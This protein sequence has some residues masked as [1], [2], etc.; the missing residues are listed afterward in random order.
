MI[1]CPNCDFEI[2][3]KGVHNGI[4]RPKCPRCHQPFQLAIFAGQEPKVAK[5]SP[6]DLA[7]LST[8]GRPQA[9]AT[10]VPQARA[11]SVASTSAPPQSPAGGGTAVTSA[12]PAPCTMAWSSRFS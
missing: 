2:E 4:F 9:G 7:M 12:P 6:A 5:L 8:S 11:T 1:F 3:L 10:P